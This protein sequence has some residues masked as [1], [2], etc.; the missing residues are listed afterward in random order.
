MSERAVRRPPSMAD[1][2]ARAGVSHQTVSRVLNAHPYVAPATREAVEA[3]ISELGYR[4]NSLARAL[5]TGR[6]TQLGVV[7]LN[8]ALY[9]PASM[10]HS[11]QR[12]ARTRGFGTSVVTLEGFAPAELEAALADLHDQNVAG[13]VV[14][15][16]LEPA[17]PTLSDRRST[18]PLVA[19]EGGQAVGLSAVDVDQRGGTRQALDHLAALGRTRIAH[20]TG[21]SG[22]VEAT[23][24]AGTWREWSERSGLQPGPEL[25]GDWSARS[26]YQ[27][28]RALLA[29]PTGRVDAVLAGNDPMALGLLRAFAQAGVR[30][31]DDVAVCGFDDIPEAAYYSPPLTTVRQD[32]TEVG[33]RCVDLVLDL[34]ED[35]TEPGSSVLVPAELVVRESTVGPRT[36]ADPGPPQ[37]AGALSGTGPAAG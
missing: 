34:I 3:A 7:S 26:G 19:V 22:W 28:G 32:F 18:V 10:L 16:P 13:V 29:D 11:I 33:R 1:V 35:R 12:A 21:P 15:A 25:A 5:V 31:P 6:T 9:G 8:S 20:V 2:A 4:R 24:R 17:S 30:V 37:V 23:A 27:A 36:A 14:I